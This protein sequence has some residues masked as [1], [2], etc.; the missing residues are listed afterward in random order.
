M[1]PDCICQYNQYMGG[2]N[3]SDTRIYFFQDKRRTNW[4]NVQD[5]F[6]LFGQTLFNV[7]IVYRSNTT[8]PL[9]YRKFLESC[10]DGLIGDFQM[11]PSTRHKVPLPMIPLPTT[12]SSP[13]SLIYHEDH[14]IVKFPANVINCC[15][16]CLASSILL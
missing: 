8:V 4:W 6:L 11:P 10:V 5:F 7:F 15:K 16:V 14:Q 2:V 3:L 13:T 9:S 12:L 1:T